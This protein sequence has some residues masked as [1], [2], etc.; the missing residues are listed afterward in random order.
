MSLLLFLMLQKRSRHSFRYINSA[1]AGIR[2]YIRQDKASRTV[3]FQFRKTVI[4]KYEV[5]K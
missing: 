5:S 2:F 4:Q 3:L 1:D